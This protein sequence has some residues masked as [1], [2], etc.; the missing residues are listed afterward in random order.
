MRR[1]A[2]LGILGMLV[3]AVSFA[4]DVDPARRSVPKRFTDPPGKRF[5]LFS[6]DPE[7]I[8][9]ANEVDLKDF[10]AKLE[11][12]KTDHSLSKI[13]TAQEDAA[14][15]QIPLIFSVRN[16]GQSHYTLSFPDAQRYDFVV[17][18]EGSDR[19]DA[20]YVWS[21][22]KMFTKEAG[23]SFVNPDDTLTFK[24][25][26]PLKKIASR[27]SKGTYKVIAILS[28]YPELKAEA[29]FSVSD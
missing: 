27:L 23:S 25:N 15:F 12:E 29:T 2:V 1:L 9:K 18:R 17:V 19:E 13:K 4:V 26:V 22:D 20:V 14:G 16:T 3:V 7:R 28:N 6:G 21:D 24:D 5:S 8:Q 11:L 10:K